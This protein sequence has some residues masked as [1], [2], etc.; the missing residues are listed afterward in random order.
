MFSYKG[1][2]DMKIEEFSFPSSTGVCTIHGNSYMPD[3]D[4][5][6]VLVIHHGMAEH[7]Q[8]YR[9]FIEYLV[10]NS[11]AV[12]MYDMANHGKSNQNFAET[13]YFGNEDGY[14]ALV[15]DMHIVFS[16]AREE[17]PDKRIIV[18][19]HSMGS[20]IVRCYTAWYNTDSFDGAIYMGTGGSNPIAGVGD[21]MSSAIA[22]IAGR[23]KKVKL[24]DTM[25]FGSYGNRTEKRTSFDWL[26]RDS[27]IVDQYIAD[28]YCGFLFSAQGM[29]DLVKLNIAANTDD[30]YKNLS[31]DL[32]I[33]VVSGA[34]DPV[35]EY[36]KGINEIKDK[37]ANTG[38]YNAT[39]KLYDGARHEILNEINKQEVYAD[40]LA[41]LDSTVSK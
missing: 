2:N 33:L 40:I 22:K 18:M 9:A 24:L 38:H 36:G 13:G 30:W 26:T 4:I 20:F 19:G 3:S 25:T 41:W 6:G 27:A 28:D 35:S 37:L 7:Q 34:E 15:K 31:T 39:V 21:K 10:S 16:K 17:H 12:Y 5:K 32:P 29:N 11:Y 23:T 14:K 8:R 1:V